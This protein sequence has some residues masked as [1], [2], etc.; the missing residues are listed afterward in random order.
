MNNCQS[1]NCKNK[2]EFEKSK[3][4]KEHACLYPFCRREREKESKFS[5]CSVHTDLVA[6]EYQKMINHFNG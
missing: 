5:S 1:T 3:Y 6:N 4:C 2:P